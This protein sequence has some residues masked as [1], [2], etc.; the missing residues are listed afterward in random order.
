MKK[1]IIGSVVAA[2]I[3]FIWQF[4][5]YAMLDL[6]GSQMAYHP[7]QDAVME[8]LEANL[9]EGIYYMPRLE[10]GASAEAQEAYY[11]EKSGKPWALVAYYDSMEYS[12]G[13]NM[14]RGLLTN[15]LAAL[16]L[17]WLLMRFGELNMKEAIIASIGVGVIGYLTITYLG[18]IYFPKNTWPDLLDAIVPWA[19]VGAWLGWWLPRGQST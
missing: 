9:E 2:L 3:L 4:L 5:S 6:H 16:I 19:L 12:M 11:A 1:L 17:C 10:K 15:F 18:N 7:N 8:S 13:Q 14:I